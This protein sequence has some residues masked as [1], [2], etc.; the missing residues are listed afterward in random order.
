MF[1][2]AANQS[3]FWKHHRLFCMC[4]SHSRSKFSRTLW[5]VSPGYLF[6]KLGLCRKCCRWACRW[7]CLSLHL[8]RNSWRITAALRKIWFP[9]AKASIYPSTSCSWKFLR[10]Q[11]Q[12]WL[13]RKSPSSLRSFSKLGTQVW[14]HRCAHRFTNRFSWNQL[15]ISWSHRC[16]RFCCRL[17]C[18]FQYLRLN[19]I[20]RREFKEWCH[21]P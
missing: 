7:C 14:S 15:Q 11:S 9:E 2:S 20:S 12:R 5:W 1:A 4:T 17:S 21:E 19:Q 10:Q 6:A 18:F 13:D 8:T 16:R 3:G